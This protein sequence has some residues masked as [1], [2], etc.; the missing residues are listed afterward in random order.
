MLEISWLG[1]S[2]DWS[3]LTC[4]ISSVYNTALTSDK[5]HYQ[6]LMIPQFF[7]IFSLD[8]RVFLLQFEILILLLRDLLKTEG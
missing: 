2:P 1:Q 8:L 5:S 4:L 7:T 3:S 6:T